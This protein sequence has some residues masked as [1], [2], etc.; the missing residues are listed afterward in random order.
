VQ[1]AL[2]AASVQW[3]AEGVPDNP[4]GWLVRVAERRL[5]DAHR[6]EAARRRREEADA[7]ADA[8]VT[9]EV[10]GE[11]DSLLLL[12]M[13]C[14][15]A[16]P[17]SAAIPLTL[18]AV[19]GLTTAEIAAAFLVPEATMAKRITRAKTRVRDAGATF[20]E[21][22]ADERVE[23]LTSVLRILYL[24]FNE[25]YAT[26]AGPDLARPDLS[27]EAIRLT[28]LAHAA[29]DDPE[30]AG[31]LA[32]MLLTE[33]RRPARTGAHGELV[34]L[35]EQ[36][37]TQWDAAMTAEGFAVLTPALARGPLGA[38]RVQAAI[39]GV[40]AEG[41]RRQLAQQDLGRGRLGHTSGSGALMISCTSMRWRMGAPPGPGAAET[42]AAI[43]MA[44]S[45]LSTSTMR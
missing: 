19:G 1:E 12:F 36:D 25:G 18:R 27:R 6:S 14:H 38:Y 17:P 30:V 10:P 13:C 11:D 20:A 42:W 4:L 37:R 28:R 9:S 26:S 3:P 8:A 45:M 32:L 40:H 5:V 16:L 22:S 23:R 31:L 15:P 24:L 41:L 34:P 21:P 33:A 39:A 44:R 35:G 2:V 7:R 43:S 29:V